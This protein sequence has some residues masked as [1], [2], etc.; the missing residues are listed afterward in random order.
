MIGGGCYA[1]CQALQ[2]LASSGAASIESLRMPSVGHGS[3][4]RRILYGSSEMLN[5]SSLIDQM[6]TL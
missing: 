2:E 6:N 3:S 4:S 5:A 1:E